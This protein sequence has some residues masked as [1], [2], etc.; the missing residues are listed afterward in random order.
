MLNKSLNREEVWVGS[1]S[2]SDSR[3]TQLWGFTPPILHWP[4]AEPRGQ[5]YKSMAEF[6]NEEARPVWEQ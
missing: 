3:T 5:D 1:V 4:Q 2:E 6:I